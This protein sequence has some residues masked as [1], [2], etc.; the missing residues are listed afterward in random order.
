MRPSIWQRL[1]SKSIAPYLFI[2]PFFI[3]FASFSLFPV[4]Y[5]LYLS[6]Q[7]A[8]GLGPRVFIGLDNYIR[9]GRDP[10]F[11]K[12][13][14]NTSVFALGS[15]A[16]QVPLGL[17][18]AL[19]LHT[20][21]TKRL[22]GLYRAAFFLPII[23]PGVVV[24]IM[25]GVIFEFDYGL[26]NEFLR[27]FNLQPVPWVRSPDYAMFSIILL[28]LWIWTGIKALYFLAGLQNIPKEYYE[29]AVI[30]GATSV[31]R[32]WRITLPQ[33]RPVMA[34]VVIQT[35]IGSYSLFDQVWVLTQGGPRDATLTMTMYL[36]TVGFQEFRLGYSA[37]IGYSI[38]FI[39]LSLSLILFTVFRGMREE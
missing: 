12:A 25:F 11:I 1:N 15:T 36:Y 27:S 14:V 30:D 5:S 9:L 20:K 13:L 24:G 26:L 35:V 6:L 16:I 31:Q 7:R 33:L 39:V 4:L 37:A 19:A 18:L 23:T 38:V 22:R 8:T 2:A 34:F 28:G 10:R 3:L 32:F 21:L 17:L 29:S